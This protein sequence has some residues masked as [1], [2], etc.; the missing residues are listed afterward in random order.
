MCGRLLVPKPL[1]TTGSPTTTATPHTDTYSTTAGT[2]VLTGSLKLIS[3]F[4][5]ALL[6]LMILSYCTVLC[7]S[8][9]STHTPLC[10]LPQ[11]LLLSCSFPISLPYRSLCRCIILCLFRDR[12]YYLS[13]M[14]VYSNILGP[15]LVLWA[16]VYIIPCP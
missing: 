16:N 4:Y 13:H 10:Q 11:A 6:S 7:V 12:E 14:I 1:I 15:M 3:H 5:I 9:T 2:L 8:S